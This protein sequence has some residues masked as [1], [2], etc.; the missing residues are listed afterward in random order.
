MRVCRKDRWLPSRFLPRTESGLLIAL[1]SIK[2]I[3]NRYLW[4][5]PFASFLTG[6]AIM[7]ML[8]QSK[9]TQTP[10]LIGKPV[11]EALILASKQ[12]LSLRLV[13]EKEDPELPAGT[14]LSQNPLPH[15]HIKTHQPIHCII[16][17]KKEYRVGHFMGKQLD[18]IKSEL[19]QQTITPH[20]HFINSSIPAGLCITQEPA[21]D[22]ILTNKSILLYISQ[23]NSSECIF[24]NLCQKPV[25]DVQR[26][27]SAAPVHV[28]LTHAF[29]Q[30]AD[31]SCT[32]CI[33]SDQRPH[34]GTIIYLDKQKP[35]SVQL[36]ATPI[37]IS[38]QE[39]EI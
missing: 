3:M 1:H 21:P 20:I 11:Q 19:D 4:I 34:A 12:G 28:Q 5:I 39:G 24:P 30:P 25:E 29:E 8:Y 2:I 18:Q 32:N 17:K 33:V 26:F 15:T 10:I 36:V 37:I 38:N 14:V 31:H 23:D 16:S 13:A 22:T 9:T 7:S 6:Y 35:I 27:L